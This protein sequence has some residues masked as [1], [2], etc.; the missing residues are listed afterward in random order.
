[1]NIQYR[2]LISND[3]KLYRDLRL[4]SLKEYPDSFCSSYADQVVKPKLAFETYIEQGHSDKI[5]IGAFLEDRSIGICGFYRTDEGRSEHRGEIIQM[6][7]KPDFQGKNIEQTLL[8][9]TLDEAFALPDL[10]HI[11]LGVLTNGQAANRVYERAGFQ[12]YGLQKNFF[13]KG[14]A[15]SHQRLMVIKGDQHKESG[16]KQTKR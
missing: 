12:E 1:M 11:E 3:S 2:K 8:Q 13:K 10:E 15:Y 4:E 5:I 7:V 9:A 16:Y 6:Y 14:N